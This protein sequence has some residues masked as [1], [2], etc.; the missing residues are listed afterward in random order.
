MGL[1][2]FSLPYSPKC[3]DGFFWKIAFR[4]LHSSKPERPTCLTFGPTRSWAELEMLWCWIKMQE[5]A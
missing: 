5:R 4:I 3:V 1:W 2:P